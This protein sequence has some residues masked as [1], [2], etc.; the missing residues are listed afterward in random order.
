MKKLENKEL[1]K[2]NGGELSVMAVLGITALAVFIA[3]I[4]DGIVN[5][6]KCGAP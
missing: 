2:I 3:G 6:R 4:I 1:E 5:P